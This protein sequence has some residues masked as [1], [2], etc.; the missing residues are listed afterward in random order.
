MALG[1]TSAELDTKQS[2]SSSIS[3]IN[4][5]VEDNGPK[6]MV[7]LP[8]DCGGVW[9]VGTKAVRDDGSEI[10]EPAAESDVEK[11]DGDEADEADITNAA[12]DEANREVHAAEEDVR[13]AEESVAASSEEKTKV[14]QTVQANQAAVD[15]LNGEVK[16]LEEAITKLTDDARKL[17]A[18]KEGVEK[19]LK[20]ARQKLDSSSAVDPSTRTILDKMDIKSCAASIGIITDELER[21]STEIGTKE[22]EKE[23]NGTKLAQKTADLNK[24][25]NELKNSKRELQNHEAL[26]QT[27]RRDLQM[28]KDA[29][30]E[31][32]A[33]LK[34][35]PMDGAKSRSAT[36]L[37]R[38]TK[39]KQDKRAGEEQSGRSAKRRRIQNGNDLDEDMSSNGISDDE[40]YDVAVPDNGEPQR[41]IPPQEL[42]DLEIF[43]DKL[44]KIGIVT[45]GV[46]ARLDDNG[47]LFLP[48]GM[49]SERAML[50][51]GKDMKSG[52]AGL[53]GGQNITRMI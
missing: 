53:P 24:A 28:A 27:H 31:K 50:I 26:I 43:V 44:F 38:G 32:Q 19:A 6:M 2:D 16:S 15:G 13:Q 51:K 3:F 5:E 41:L 4:L 30:K 11:T 23:T 8:F 39:Q 1:E 14:E 25:N 52:C 20:E 10:V 18:D 7:N 48:K 17:N 46:E 40:M 21:I 29:L 42:G 49:T 12:V 36:A 37:E 33:A 9:L 22:Q 47:N 35:R 45:L 34:K